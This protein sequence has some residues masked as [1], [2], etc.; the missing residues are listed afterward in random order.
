MRTT[1]DTEDMEPT[2][3]L[4]AVVDLAAADTLLITL[5]QR[6][7]EGQLRRTIVVFRPSG[8]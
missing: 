6:L 2:M 3:T 4:P 8:R 1:K 5:R 7:A